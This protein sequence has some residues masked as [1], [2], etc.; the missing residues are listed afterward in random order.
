MVFVD[1]YGKITEY[2]S[3]EVDSLK[4]FI[5]TEL[6]ELNS[7]EKKFDCAITKFVGAKSKHIRSVLAFLYLKSK[8]FEI[9]EK[10]IRFQAII[11]LIHNASLIHDDVI[12]GSQVRRSE[13]SLNANLGNHL[14]VIGGDFVLSYVLKYLVNLGE[15]ELLGMVSDTI[16]TMCK[17]EVSQYYSK[18]EIPKIDEYLK[19]TYAKTGALFE[20]ALSGAEFLASGKIS[21]ET[22]DFAKNFGIAFQIRDDI[23]NVVDNPPNGDIQ[24]GIYTAPVIFSENIT[25]PLAGL[26]KAKDLLDNYIRQS[27][28]CLKNS[29]ES[30]Y[31]RA[32]CEL[33]DLIGNE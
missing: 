13:K 8:G 31:K 29:D 28:L 27:A 2:V 17:G 1:K 16:S 18:Y 9:D 23:K 12:D 6:G 26:E 15:I 20:L 11:E 3:K 19:K 25:E 10:Q 21:E 4:N 5:D 32:I 7:G 24:N 22:K 14:S 30:D 33:L